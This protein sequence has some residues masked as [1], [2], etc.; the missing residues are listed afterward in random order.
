MSTAL[1]TKERPVLRSHLVRWDRLTKDQQSVLL[2]YMPSDETRWS[3]Y[4]ASHT[5]PI[6]LA[7]WAPTR[8]D[9]PFIY[10]RGIGVFPIR[11][12]HS[13]FMDA[14]WAF[15]M[16]F[17]NIGAAREQH[18][19]FYDAL[20]QDIPGVIYRSSVGSYPTINRR[21]RLSSHE[22]DFLITTWPKMELDGVDL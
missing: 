3:S 5:I 7:N 10:V 13:D 2:W 14:L 1:A 15:L 17:K 8:S 21:H 6:P 22:Y 4:A 19:Y 20:L 18:G 11:V 16:G 9:P 12:D